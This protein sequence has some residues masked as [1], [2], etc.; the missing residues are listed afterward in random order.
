MLVEID[1]EI[2]AATGAGGLEQQ[3][4]FGGNGSAMARGRGS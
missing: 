4:H 3:Q 2:H 1:P